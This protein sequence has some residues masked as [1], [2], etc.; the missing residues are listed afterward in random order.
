MALQG[1]PWCGAAVGHREESALP[2]SC[3]LRRWGCLCLLLPALRVPVCCLDGLQEWHKTPRGWQEGWQPLPAP[4]AII[5]DPGLVVRGHTV[6]MSR[7]V[8]L[9]LS[10]CLV[11]SH[12]PSEGPRRG[13][14]SRWAARAGSAR[15]LWAGS[16]HRG[17]SPVHG[18][19][20]A[21]LLS[22]ESKQLVCSPCERVWRCSC[23]HLLCSVVP[24]AGSVSGSAGTAGLRMSECGGTGLGCGRAIFNLTLSSLSPVISERKA[25]VW[26]GTM[27][28]FAVLGARCQGY[29]ELNCFQK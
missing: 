6:R 5:G 18:A 20:V 23:H 29:K 14:Q 10:W 16:C 1:C 12:T 17:S 2:L 21:A 4:G 25:D 19:G 11:A 8:H 26:Q 28:P 9:V 7:L 13:T 27:V 3:P 15:P 22:L 24:S